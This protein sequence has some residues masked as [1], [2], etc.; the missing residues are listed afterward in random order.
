MRKG[1]NYYDGL[2]K[3]IILAKKSYIPKG[4]NYPKVGAVIVD[5]SGN[6]IDKACKQA[7]IHAE[8]QMLY[9]LP[10]NYFKKKDVTLY[11][12]LEPCTHRNNPNDLSCSDHIIRTGI[13]KVVIGMLD[14]NPAIS[15]KS[16]SYLRKH[17]VK[18]IVDN[19]YEKELMR[20]N[21]KFLSKKRVILFDLWGTLIKKNFR[22]ADPYDVIAKII[23]INNKQELKR[24]SNS[25]MFLSYDDYFN[26][27]EKDIIGR[28]LSETDKDKIKNVIEKNK[29]IRLFKDTIPVLKKLRKAGYKLG[30]LSNVM[31][32]GLD[33]IKKMFKKYVDFQF[34]SCEDGM[35]K[36]DLAFFNKAINY[37]KT[38]T[39]DVYMVGDSYKY[40]I[41]GAKNAGIKKIFFIT[42]KKKAINEA[43]GVIKLDSLSD[44]IPYLIYNYK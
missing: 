11:T 34:Y 4:K 22:N 26:F 39:S 8:F 1:Y 27:I 13:S 20:I 31:C 37:F 38:D 28:K 19:R 23:K 35:A 12:T 42:N 29:N 41:V 33:K 2:K 32:F 43:G 40:D 36:P 18:V 15:G 21:E 16:V 24:I 25:K 17:K 30:I 9:K 6:I 7:K 3:A 44:I 14:P 10:D 5:E